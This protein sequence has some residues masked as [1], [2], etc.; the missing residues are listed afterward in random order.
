M[1]RRMALSCAAIALFGSVA[2]CPFEVRG[3]S[4]WRPGSASRLAASDLRRITTDR[5]ETED[6]RSIWSAQLPGNHPLATPAVHDGVLYVGGGFGSHEMYAISAANGRPIWGTRV[7]DD[8]PTAAL[9]ADDYV[10]FN[11]ESCTIFILSRRDGEHL[12]SKWLGDPLLSQPAYAGGRIVTAYPGDGGHRVASFE[13]R[14]G[15]LHWDVAVD[16][17]IV[18]APVIHQGTVYFTTYA[19]TMFALDLDDG[20]VRWRQ[21]GRVTSAPFVQGGRI[22]ASLRVDRRGEGPREG[23]Q[24]FSTTTGRAILATPLSVRDAPYLDAEV[25]ARSQLAGAQSRQNAGV[26][27]GTPP[28]AARA[29]LAAALVGQGNVMGMWEYQGSRPVLASFDGGNPVLVNAM[30]DSVQALDPV[31]GQSHWS[32]GMTLLGSV[33]RLGGALV[34]AP[35]I[36]RGGI[37]VG[38]SSGAL[39]AMD[40]LSGRT[41]WSLMVDQPIRYQPAVDRGWIYLGTATGALVAVDTGNPNLTGWP[42]WGRHPAH[43]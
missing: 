21:S 26:G 43:L 19:G 15:Q 33:R 32:R 12:W 2:L 38:T 25:Q 36:T 13:A 23:I 39:V 4:R 10:I 3:Q 27:F 14:D 22:W 18:T 37:V 20:A 7:S 30:G 6:G 42:M 35:A 1:M 8:G 34:T 24:A 29:D 41:T 40:P 17:E 11:T 5:F 31:S 28:A 16:G 9:V